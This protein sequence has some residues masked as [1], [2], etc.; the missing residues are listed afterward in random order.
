MTVKVVQGLIGANSAATQAK[1]A[2]TVSTNAAAQSSSST[3]ASLS[4]ASTEAVNVSIR[5]FKAGASSEKIRD[6][7]EARQVADQV[8]DQIKD[9][10]D[11]LDAHQGL[12]ASSSRP[13]FA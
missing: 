3:A 11:S 10:G 2:Q 8:A 13:H 9:K 1:Q 12:T 5:S 4:Y 6:A 7:K